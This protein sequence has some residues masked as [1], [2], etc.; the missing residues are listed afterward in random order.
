MLYSPAAVTNRF[1]VSACQVM[2]GGG[3]HKKCCVLRIVR[4][5]TGSLLQ[6]RYCSV[7]LAI[8]RKGPAKITVSSSE[9]WVQIDR[10]LELLSKY[11]GNGRVA[12]FVANA[13]TD[14]AVKITP[15]LR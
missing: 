15:T 2:R 5:H 10:A 14:V 7:R 3:A 8:E 6:M 1:A 9:V 12:A 11:Y 13:E 4:A